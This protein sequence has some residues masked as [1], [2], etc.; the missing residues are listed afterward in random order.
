MVVLHALIWRLLHDPTRRHAY[1]TYA[2]QFVRDQMYWA[3]LLAHQAELTPKSESLERW[4]TGQGGGV[5][6][7]AIGGPS[8]ATPWAGCWW[9]T[10]T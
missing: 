1:V 2:A 3:A 7:T 9:W 8:P 5:V 4:Y 6:A 10:T